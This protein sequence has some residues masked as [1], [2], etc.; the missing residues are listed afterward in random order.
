MVNDL[1]F[2]LESNLLNVRLLNAINLFIRE[3]VFQIGRAITWNTATRPRS[4]VVIRNSGRQRKG[5]DVSVYLCYC[6][7]TSGLSFV[8][9][10]HKTILL[11]FFVVVVFVIIYQLIVI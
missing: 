2:F 8:K 6:K 7:L 3:K 11:V 4:H 1:A 9:K 10:N 5:R